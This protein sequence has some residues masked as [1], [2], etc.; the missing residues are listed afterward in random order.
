MPSK[1]FRDCAEYRP[2]DEFSKNSRSR[3]GPAFYC[4]E[5]LAE[6]SSRSHEARRR[7][8]RVQ[9]R[10]VEGTVVPPGHKWCPDCDTVLPLGTSSGR[11]PHRAGSRLVQA[12]PQ[13]TA[14]SFAG[15]GRRVPLVSP[16]YSPCQARRPRPR[17]RCRPSP[18][19]L[20]LQRRAR[21]VQGRSDVPPR[22]RL[23]RGVPYRAA[24]HR[25]RARG[26]EQPVG[27]ANRTGE[28]PVGSHR[29]PGRA[30]S[31][32]ATGRTSGS[33]RRDAGGD[34]VS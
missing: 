23:L 21:P 20:R 1:F 13:F 8:P 18:V 22:R 5:H 6:R 34:V 32:R 2:V 29:R 30:R 33:R 9:R 31:T 24:G 7:K 26:G 25:R 14:S 3:D 4:R 28:P 11:W 15:E 16:R 17:D 27:R 19:V 12:L 10:P